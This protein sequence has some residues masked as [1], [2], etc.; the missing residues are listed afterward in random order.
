MLPSMRLSVGYGVSTTRVFLKEGT[1]GGMSPW[2]ILSKNREVCKTMETSSST[3]MA[4][5]MLVKPSSSSQ[6]VVFVV[7]FFSCFAGSFLFQIKRS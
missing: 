1:V 5:L 2:K 4:G 7:V 3:F 6:P